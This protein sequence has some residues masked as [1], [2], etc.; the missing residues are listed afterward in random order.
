MKTILVLTDL[1]ENAAHAALSALMLAKQMH[2]NVLLFN[3]NV[4]QPVAPMYAGGP[5]VADVTNIIEYDNEEKLKNLAGALQALA[6]NPGKWEPQ[7]HYE[8]KLGAL[9]YNVKRLKEQK[10]IE[11]IVMGA[12]EGSGM[13]HFL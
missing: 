2:A 5:T 9:A 8:E 6:T 10:N 13:D 3:D 7:I 12:R 11:M 4:S 1:S